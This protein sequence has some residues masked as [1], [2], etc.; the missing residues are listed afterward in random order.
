M[1]LNSAKFNGLFSAVGQNISWRRSY[2]CPCVNPRSG[3]ADTQCATCNGRGRLWLAPVASHAVVGNRDALRK[4]T[5]YGQLDTGD[6]LLSLPSDQAVY[7]CGEYDRI[8]MKDKSEPFSLNLISGLNDK[9]NFT[10]SQ[11]DRVFW[12][13]ATK[14]IVDGSIPTENADGSLTFATNAPPNG[15]TYSVSGRR[16]P[17]YYCYLAVPVDRAHQF[18]EKL[19]RRIVLRRFDLFGR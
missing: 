2:A 18:G 7:D 4:I 1:L 17:E 5:D 9:L 10:A 3:Q 19:P 8:T 16:F 11:I 15:L 12:L 13:D 14:T 6:M